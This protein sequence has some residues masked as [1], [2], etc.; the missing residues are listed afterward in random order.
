MLSHPPPSQSASAA[1]RRRRAERQAAYRRRRDAGVGTFRLRLE[2]HHLEAV[3]VQVGVLRPGT[4]SHCE[5]EAAL[6]WLTVDWL[7][8]WSRRD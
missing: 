4:H 3:L 6:N 7:E 1:R 2:N 5:I 8:A